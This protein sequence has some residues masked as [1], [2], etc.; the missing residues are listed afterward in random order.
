MGPAGAALSEPSGDARRFQRHLGLLL[1][2]AVALR[3]ALWAQ[4]S[5]LPFLDAPLYDSDVY[6]H[7]ARQLRAGR[8]G[9]PSLV[10]YSPLYGWVLALLGVRVPLTIALQLALGTGTLGL[11]VLLA[12]RRA[13][14]VAGLGAGLLWL[15]YGLPL[16]YETKILSETLG[17]ALGAGGLALFVEGAERRSA[18]AMARL[19]F[20]AGVVLALSTVARASMLF[21]LLLY[22]LCALPRLPS[23]AQG[24]G[25]AIE[26]TPRSP[27]SRRWRLARAASVAAGIALVLGANGLWNRAHTGLFVPVILVSRTAA[28]ATQHDWR[29]DFRVF[30]ETGVTGGD[31]SPWDVVRQAEE[32]LREQHQGKAMEV[33]GAPLW[34][35]DLAGWIHRAPRKL[36]ATLSDRE[37]TFDYGYYGERSEVPVLGALPVSFGLLWVLALG[38]TAGLALR[39]RRAGLMT[40]WPLVPLIAGTLVTTTLFYPTSRY[41]LPMA[42]PLVLLAAELVPSL[43]AL[44]RRA[45]GSRWFRSLLAVLLVVLAGFSLRTLARRPEQPADWELRLAEAWMRAGD[46]AEAHR[47]MDRARALAPGDPAVLHRIEIITRAG[48]SAR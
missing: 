43:G 21:A 32:R 22:P 3:V 14:D 7:Q 34:G 17:L 45:G 33:R 27:T 4:S 23:L 48:P 6:L 31:V 15:G 18:S 8:F 28:V 42:L 5:A 47:R 25:G 16:F 38:G 30:S 19:S 46:P 41:R 39:R 10:A 44:R 40:L 13:G 20:A 35:V 9:D 2:A 26:A 1:L 36:L 24:V 12:R 29:G 37:T 11:V